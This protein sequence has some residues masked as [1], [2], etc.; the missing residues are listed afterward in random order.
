MRISPVVDD[1]AS[2]SSSADYEV[3]RRWED[4]LIFQETL[5]TEYQRMARAKKKRLLAGRGVK[6]HG[7]YIHD[8]ASS[9]E[10]LPPGPHPDSV[11]LD[12]HAYLP[13]LTK[14]GTVFRTSL[15]TVEKRNSEITALLQAIFSPNAPAL[16]HELRQ[17]RIITDFF[18]YWRRDEDLARKQQRATGE[19]RTSSSGLSVYFSSHASPPPTPSTATLSSTLRRPK[20]PHTSPG[21]LTPSSSSYVSTDP[22]RY[23]AC[24]IS[25]SSGS[26]SGASSVHSRSSRGSH[27]TSPIVHTQ[28]S[29]ISFDHNPDHISETYTYDGSPS[30][31]ASLPEEG[32]L[33][34]DS[35]VSQPHTSRNPGSHVGEGRGDRKGQI[36]LIPP[37]S[38]A[39]SMQDEREG[40]SSP[41]LDSM[42]KRTV[43][44]IILS[45]HRF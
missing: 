42:H 40:N 10:S 9:F 4:C 6:K 32:E 28:D 37:F 16:L 20:R 23:H 13:K 14:K 27:H 33:N 44:D 1:S 30:V 19:P 5:E 8:L 18:G 22:S 35:S 31:L 45:F 26:S 38:P 17:E 25:T 2:V 41:S 3:W 12:V 15:A 21:I 11:S 24:N 43:F 29:T 36:F 7:V 39:R 34:E